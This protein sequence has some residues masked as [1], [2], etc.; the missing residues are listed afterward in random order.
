[1]KIMDDNWINLMGIGMKILE[2]W[3]NFFKVLGKNRLS[4]E[5][6]ME[7]MSGLIILFSFFVKV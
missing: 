6:L 2:N 7:V 5:D 1:M 4:N 3:T